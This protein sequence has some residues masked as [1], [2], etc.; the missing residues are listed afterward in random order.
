MYKITL[1][2]L[3]V[4][5]GCSIPSFIETDNIT[6][7]Q[8]SVHVPNTNGVLHLKAKGY[9]FFNWITNT[10]LAV[11][12]PT[13]EEPIFDF[14][15]F[16]N[17][18]NLKKAKERLKK[19]KKYPV[20]STGSCFIVD[21]F[22]DYYYAV[23]AKHV[24]A[25]IEPEV[26]IDNQKGEVVYVLPRADAAILRF[27]SNKIYPIYKISI[28]AKVMDDAWLVGYP[29]DVI[30]TIR[31]F[32]VKGYVCNVSK[33]ELWFAGGG[34][35]GMSGG[36]ML[37]DKDE[38]VGIISKFLPSLHPCDNFINNVPSRYFKY[39]LEVIISKEKIKDLTNRINILKKKKS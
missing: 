11:M 18:E 16:E 4:F 35:R 17:G 37:N 31:K 39:A 1:L 2:V 28:K 20:M 30:H 32:T 27:K 26:F 14:D 24:V 22:N 10:K 33:T 34:A 15:F 5:S 8:R 29:G 21:K 38:V 13:D 19:L 23:T 12:P 3:L 36:P 25:M 9:S 6:I 7:F